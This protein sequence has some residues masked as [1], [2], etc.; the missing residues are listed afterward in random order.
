MD[1][2]NT[3]ICIAEDR[4]TCEPSLRLLLLSLRRHCPDTTI[5]LFYPPANDDFRRWL[6]AFPQVDLQPQP[7]RN[8]YGWNVKPQA[9]MQLLDAGFDEVI[10]IDSDVLVTGD[11]IGLFGEID[12]AT[13]V[14][15]EH[16]LGKERNDGNGHR[17][18]AWGLPVGRTLPA[19]VNSGVVRITKQHRPLLER[20]WVMLQSDE[21]QRSQRE[22]WTC[23]PLHMLGDQDVLT[24]LLAAKEYSHVPLRI[25][26]RGRHIIQ[27]D[28]VWGYTVAERIQNL[29]GNGPVF[30]HSIAAK[31]WVE[32][33]PP[34]STA[35]EYLKLVYLDVSP[36]TLS[37]RTFA[38]EL[39]AVAW[40][41]PHFKLGSVLRLMGLG[42]PALSG[43]PMA[44]L[45][46]I[47]RIVNWVR[48]AL[49]G[50]VASTRNSTRERDAIAGRHASN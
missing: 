1:T 21:Y 14:A 40:M 7:L 26:R 13:L 24:A 36:Y 11:M 34:P 16:P 3:T 8:G 5:S 39:A 31:P 50:V 37:A 27:F 47:V 4:A 45:G 48:D 30:I 29:L 49:R 33:W 17:A 32:P 35:K 15:T 25:L 2:T 28:G 12:G 19:A 10:W 9:L 46:D 20:W 38:H 23:R 18:R 41:D 43:L 42:S 44:V 6:R 22:S